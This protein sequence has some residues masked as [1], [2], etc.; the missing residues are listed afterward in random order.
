MAAQMQN[1][2]EN[3][4]SDNSMNSLRQSQMEEMPDS[5]IEQIAIQE[6]KSEYEDIGINMENYQIN[7]ILMT[8]LQMLG[9]ALISMTTAVI[10]MLL[11]SKVAAKLGATLREK[12]IKKF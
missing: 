7:Y 1:Q 12:Y 6:I 5:I 10:I 4:L 9:I 11:S 3:Y 2:N 8:G